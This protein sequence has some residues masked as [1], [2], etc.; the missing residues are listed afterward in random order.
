MLKNTLE[1]DK[2]VQ[3]FSLS[4]MQKKDSFILQ[5]AVNVSP[6]IREKVIAD[7]KRFYA[8]NGGILF[9]EPGVTVVQSY[10]LHSFEGI[11][12]YLSKGKI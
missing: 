11:C 8:E 4:E 2:A 5:Y 9:Q 10:I 1:Y 12:L 6:D 7:F 3:E